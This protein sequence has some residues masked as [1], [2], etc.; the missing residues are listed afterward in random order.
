M[1]YKSCMEAKK[2][3]R[4]WTIVR[5][6]KREKLSS[7]IMTNL[8][9]LKL[10][11]SWWQSMIVHDSWWSNGSARSTI[12]DYHKPFYQGFRVDLPRTVCGSEFLN[13]EKMASFVNIFELFFPFGMT[14]WRSSR[15]ERWAFFKCLRYFPLQ[16]TEL[17]QEIRSVL[18]Q[19]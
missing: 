7:T 1:V 8:N 14:S 13:V 12:I 19:A 16:V 4:L 10:N 18:S 6:V 15:N 5:V 17:W 9:K 3:A 2:T 11:D